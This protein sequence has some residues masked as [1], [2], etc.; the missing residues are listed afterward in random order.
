MNDPRVTDEAFENEKLAS[1]LSFIT[2]R[3]AVL[4]VRA[5][6]R[7]EDAMRAGRKFNEDDPYGALYGGIEL[8]ELQYVVAK[9]LDDSD[10]L[11][12]EVHI[13][14]KLLKEPYFARVDFRQDGED[15]AEKI[16][17]GLKNLY[18]EDTMEMFVCDWR[19]P[20]ASLFYND[21]DGKAYYDVPDGKIRGHIAL[22]RQYKFDNGRLVYAVDSD[23]KIDDEILRD[24]LAKSSTD[25]L[26]VIVSSIQR[27]Q[28]SAIRYSGNRNLLVSGPAG[29][30]KTSIGMHRM[31]Y[32]LYNDRESLFSSDIYMFT[33]NNLFASYV[34]DIIPELGERD[35]QKTDLFRLLRE[36]IDERYIVYDHYEQAQA[37][38]S[39]D[40]KR[41]ASIAVK[42]S[43]KFLNTLAETA[44]D[45]S[46]SFEDVLVLN[47]KLLGTDELKARYLIESEA[48][49]EA[50]KRERLM[51]YASDRCEEYFAMHREE[52]FEKLDAML[53]PGDSVSSHFNI[54]KRE[55]KFKAAQ[56]VSKALTPDFVKLYL[57]A[58]KSFC[59]ENSEVYCESLSLLER[60]AI[61]YE[62]ML[63]I[64]YLK[65]VFGELKASIAPKHI[66]I[67]EAQDICPLAH[68]LIYSLFEKSRF[69]LLADTNQAILPQ[70]NTTDKR[71]LEKIYG[72][73]TISLN[74]S[75]RSTTQINSVATGLLEKPYEIFERDGERVE[76][77]KSGDTVSAL[78]EMLNSEK[79]RGRSTCVITLTEDEAAQLYN[80]LSPLTGVTLGVKNAS[81]FPS[82]A[83]IMPL[84]FVKGLEFD[85]V[86]IPDAEKPRFTGAAGKRYL[87]MMV[88]RALHSLAFVYKNEPCVKE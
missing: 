66:L 80:A 24:V 87:Y 49:N 21:F 86:I 7:L 25:K 58:L 52:I 44:F 48:K 35:I 65:N 77:I 68:S 32:L 64:L 12:R 39:G 38:I 43:E 10:E 20:V 75:Y 30:G 23:I 88:T 8:T 47:E 76:F 42:Y 3:I 70:V 79:Y 54:L 17:I 6:K 15:E 46:D 71:T 22:K 19:A 2:E 73:D 14:K 74:K 56:A 31:A 63:C 26:K 36:G 1:T 57:N 4:G 33:S 55:T 82:G 69:T 67:D 50:L 9:E 11:K 83:V 28:N 40:A 61:N 72:C 59:G 37:L 18:D 78:A 60:G 27:E 85:N 62:D 16:Y 53:D 81:D 84:A 5:E 51:R 34:A 29:S 45:S 41:A 13:L